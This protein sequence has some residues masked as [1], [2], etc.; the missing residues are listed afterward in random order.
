VVVQKKQKK[1]NPVKKSKVFNW[2]T[3]RKAA[4]L[5]MSTGL[6]TQRE[7]CR[8]LHLTEKTMCEWKKAPEFMEEIDALTLKNENFTRAGLLK[9][10][11][12]GLTKQKIEM[13]A[14]LKHSGKI[15]LNT[16]S[17]EELMEIITNDD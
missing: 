11:L 15:D 10:C 12:K 5:A 16:L 4:A 7:I 13:D 6:K 3:Q 17:D 14:N 8:E 1:V 2:T 9:E